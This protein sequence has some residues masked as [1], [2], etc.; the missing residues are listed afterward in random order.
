MRK[1]TAKHSQPNIFTS[2]ADW[3]N[4]KIDFA[5]PTTSVKPF[6]KD[7]AGMKNLS[8]YLSLESMTR[9]IESMKAEKLSD[10]EIRIRLENEGYGTD[11]IDSVSSSILPSN[12]VEKAHFN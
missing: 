6:G 4:R 10:A 11:V 2:E 7:F 3:A 1:L 12:Q 5:E 9:R 8:E